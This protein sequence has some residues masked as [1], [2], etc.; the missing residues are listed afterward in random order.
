M[1][2]YST[3][4]SHVVV[5][6]FSFYSAIDSFMDSNRRVTHVNN[7]LQFFF[8]EVVLFYVSQCQHLIF[9]LT[10]VKCTY[11][12]ARISICSIA[13]HCLH[14]MVAC[15]QPVRPNIRSQYIR[16][17]LAS[18]AK[19]GTSGLPIT[20]MYEY[21]NEIKNH[22]FVSKSYFNLRKY[23]KNLLYNLFKFSPT[24]SK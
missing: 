16:T 4:T 9:R 24:M 15:V 18:T 17:Y 21:E 6:M 1:Q 2:N 12:S 3:N 19:F 11:N 7:F 20:S 8:S 5:I 10:F 13:I 22:N 14:L 23:S